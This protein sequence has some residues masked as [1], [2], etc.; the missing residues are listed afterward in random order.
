MQMDTCSALA[1]LR[2]CKRPFACGFHILLWR[3]VS[4]LIFQIEIDDDK[5]KWRFDVVELMCIQI[6]KFSFDLIPFLHGFSIDCG[7]L[8]WTVG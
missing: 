3:F 7:V 5:I 8:S 6:R 1:I 2:V 4:I